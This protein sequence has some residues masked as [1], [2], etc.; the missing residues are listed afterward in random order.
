MMLIAL[1]LFTFVLSHVILVMVIIAFQTGSLL[2]R[3]LVVF[4]GA[5]RAF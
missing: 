3:W 5:V 1:D 4:N 2:F